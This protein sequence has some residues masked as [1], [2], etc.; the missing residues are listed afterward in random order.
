MNYCECS[1]FLFMRFVIFY[2]CVVLSYCCMSVAWRL[3]FLLLTQQQVL[4]LGLLNLNRL[5]VKVYTDKYT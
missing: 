3:K 1:L 4:E 2:V 5:S